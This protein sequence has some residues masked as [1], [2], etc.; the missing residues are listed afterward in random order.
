MS[1]ISS[2]RRHILAALPIFLTGTACLAGSCDAILTS[3]EKLR[4][5]QL[6]FRTIGSTDWAEMPDGGTKLGGKT[7]FL[8]V[9][10]ENFEKER[11]GTVIIKTG[12]LRQPEEMPSDPYAKIV[13]LSRRAQA[14]NNAPCG[15]VIPFGRKFVS[16]KSYDDYH[17]VASSTGDDAALDAFHF[18]YVARRNTCHSTNSRLG[19]TLSPYSRSNR[20]QFSFDERVVDSG[21]YFQLA[22]LLRVSTASAASEKL[23]DQHV[24]TRQYHVASGTPECISFRRKPSGTGYFLRINDLEALS[25]EIRPIRAPEHRWPLPKS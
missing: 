24:E 1:L 13:R 11:S 3:T 2:C 19:D 18:S 16:P 17:D 4:D 22:V 21:T 6:F 9:V 8:Y 10:D 23:A 25:G 5:G 15:N 12:R 14:F 7:E 20:G